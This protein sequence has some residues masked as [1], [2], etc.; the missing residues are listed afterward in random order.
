MTPPLGPNCPGRRGFLLGVAASASGLLVACSS[1]SDLARVGTP[2]SVGAFEGPDQAIRMNAWVRIAADGAVSV[3]LQ[4]A[5]MGQGVSTVL[6]LLVAEEL[7]CDWKRVRFVL[8]QPGPLH[9][10]VRILYESL[11]FREDEEGLHVEAARWVAGQAAR[12]G[13]VLTGG[14]TSVRDAWMP[15]RLAGASARQMLL[16]AASARWKLSAATLRTEAGQ[17]IAAD[18]RRIGFGELAADAVRQTLPE[19]LDLK[20]P[21]RWTLLGRPV[22]RLDAS[23]KSTGKALFGADIRLPG[24]LYAA[25]V[26]AP[27]AGARLLEC[28]LDEVRAQPGVRAALIAPSYLGSNPAVVVVA[29]NT[30]A[31]QKAAEVLRPRWDTS[32]TDG[33]DSDAYQ[34]VLLDALERGKRQSWRREG[35]LQDLIRGPGLRRVDAEYQTPFLAHAALEPQVCTALFHRSGRRPSLEIWVP[36]QMPT[37]AMRVASAAAD[38]PVDAIRLHPTL[39]GGG[40]GYK[41]LPDAIAQAVSAAKALPD[42]P[43]QVQWTR[44]QDLMLDA[45]RPAAAARLSAWIDRDGQLRAWRHVSASASVVQSSLGRTA[46]SW[47]AGLVPDKTTIEGAFD[48]AYTLGAVEVDHCIV[49]CPVPVGFWRSVG[50]SHQAFFV[51]TFLDEVAVAAGS[52]PLGYRRKLLETKP[53]HLRVLNAAADAAGWSSAPGPGRARGIAF[54]PSFGSLCAQVAE[55]SLRKDGT[56]QVDRVVC[57]VDCGTALQPDLVRQQMEGGIVFGLS[58]A[59]HGAIRFVHGVAQASN[60]DAY[61]LLKLAQ[62]PEVETVILNSGAA[63]GGIGEVATPPIAP[64]LGNALYAL[65]GERQRSLPFAAQKRIKA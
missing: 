57:A 53:R 34:R 35:E 60:F 56:V 46:P 17:V 9:G 61:P 52:D 14:S 65:L 24:Q 42:Q 32:K 41:G 38:L 16:A 25:A 18:G 49:P 1:M 40:F 21:E 64:A 8:E 11:P 2:L 50:H 31:A 58:A 12:L 45:Y 39:I 29:E 15:L 22:P 23:D 4:R 3:S 62:A 19:R 36:T 47:V 44:A 7:D 33:F 26:M 28:S 63:L 10:N 37:I 51:E 20:P 6:P 59:L 30:W 13:I 5:E 27:S 43:I 54:H 48:N 55:V